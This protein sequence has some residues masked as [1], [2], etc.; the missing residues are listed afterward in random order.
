MKG[1]IVF[2]KGKLVTLRPVEEKDI[3]VI[4]KW[5]N[6]EEVTY[7][8][9][10]GQLPMSTLQAAEMIKKQVEAPNNVVLIIEDKETN[11]PIGF[12]GIYDIHPTARKAEFRILIGE[13][14]YWTKGYGTETI[15]LL[16]FYCFD[17]LNLNRVWLGVTDEN[18]AAVRA[19]EKAGYKVEGVLRQDIY[20]NSRYYNS[21]RMSILRE[22]YYPKLYEKHK[23]KFGWKAR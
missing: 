3:S 20:R 6:D 13:K 7:Y 17:R 12:G 1:K 8:M 14:D 9:F 22:E 10:Y 5:L 23:I 4:A 16:T 15:E 2:L 19:Y 21:I 11:R 18:K